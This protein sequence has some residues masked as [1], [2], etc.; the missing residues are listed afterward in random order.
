MG[1]AL[2]AAG[3]AMSAEPARSHAGSNTAASDD[4]LDT[5]LARA[6]EHR[7]AG[8]WLAALAIYE[9]L[10]QAFPADDAIH[11]LR[12][13]TL[14]DLGSAGLAW[15]LYRERPGAF[16]ADDAAR[17]EHDLLA[18][19]VGWS[20]VRMD[21]PA[22]S[23]RAV[24][25]ALEQ[26]Q[27]HLG[28]RNPAEGGHDD[29]RVRMDEVYALNASARHSEAVSA[30]R[31]LLAEGVELPPYVLAKVGDSLLA[32]REPREAAGVLE[33]AIALNPDDHA[34]RLLLAY[35][36]LESER[37]HDARALLRGIAAANPPWRVEDGAA[38]PH[39]NWRRYDADTNLALI[40]GYGNDLPFA[41]QQLE[42]MAGIAPNNSGLQSSLGQVYQMRGWPDRGLERQRMA[43][44]LD[45]DSIAARVGILEGL[46]ALRRFDQAREHRD[47]LLSAFGDNTQVRRASRYW[48]AYRGWRGHALTSGG[49][50]RKPGDTA[51]APAF[52]N[53]EGL[54]EVL[55]ESPLLADRWR[56]SGA[57]SDRH[58]DFLGNRVHARH[59]AIGLRYTHDAVDLLV[60]GFRFH[61]RWASG[62]GI[63]AA[64][65]WRIS[66]TVDAGLRI[67]RKDPLASLQARASG[68]T[69]DSVQASLAW[70]PTERSVLGTSIKQTRYS[71]G[72][73]RQE[74]SGYGVQ[75]LLS[76]PHLTV[77]GTADLFAGRASRQGVP[78][79]NPWRDQSWELGLRTRH[80]TW[81]RYEW[82]FQQRLDMSIGQYRQ[83]RYGTA[84]VP[85]A[86]YRHEWGLGQGRTL[87]Y[88]VNWAKPVY[89]GQ[90][91][92]H[93][94]WD[95]E[96]RWGWP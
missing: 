52:G 89:D 71:D 68:I 80:T 25:A 12:V 33:Q 14:A 91:E 10:R 49:R 7:D 20:E 47:A 73:R 92:R 78:Y 85:R 54:G 60:Q 90:R 38:S 36:Y 65:D 77:D 11:R 83:H 9:R 45:P 43:R 40:H 34:A 72:N 41:Q 31:Q 69:G 56:F 95:V 5:L 21:S 19:K 61:D 32:S 57:L 35:A 44:T 28:A 39:Q 48:D 13:M 1:C 18:R 82:Q 50:N 42:T 75:R 46:I 62:N 51:G 23:Q 15:Q 74:W 29:L 79:F 53:R 93:L 55:V 30:Y 2:L 17:L 8:D 87:S 59:G 84:W 22:Q 16:T 26:V 6:A 67:A 3:S 94:G 24:H 27:S 58:A 70:S 81:R 4:A 96:Y 64:L 86:R 76:H 63:A 88:G 66:D 37:H